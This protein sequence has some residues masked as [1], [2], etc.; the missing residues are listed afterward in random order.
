MS[1]TVPASLVATT[2]SRVEHG[3]AETVP[4][5]APATPHVNAKTRSSWMH[6]WRP[7]LRRGFD[8]KLG[9]ADIPAAASRDP[10]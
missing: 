8:G 9:A 5:A 3:D 1:I 10:V 7:F 2:W 6:L 4:V